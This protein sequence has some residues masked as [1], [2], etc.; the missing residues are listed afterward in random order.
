MKRLKLVTLWPI[1][2]LLLTV[3]A[4]PAMATTHTMTGNMYTDWGVNLSKAYSDDSNNLPASYDGWKPK[5]S[6]VDWIVENNI[7]RQYHAGQYSYGGTDLFN[8]AGSK[9]GTHKMKNGTSSSISDYDEPTIY[10]SDQGKYYIQPAGGEAYD[11]EALYFDDDS[12]NVYLAIV[13]SVP[14]GGSSGWKMGDIALDINDTNGNVAGGTT[15]SYEYGIKVLGGSFPAGSIIYKPTWDKPPSN[16]FPNDYPFTIQSGTSAGT[17][18]KINYTS[19]NVPPDNGFSNSVIEIS[20]PRNKLGNP[21]KDQLSNI[22]LTI[23]CGN[24][25]IELKPVRFK[26]DIPE[27]PSIVLPV[28]SILGLVFIYGSRKIN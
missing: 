8:W 16:E 5:D 11:I 20:I 27:F 6:S 1:S 7:D 24:D 17:V 22:H 10:C 19:D 4:V 21:S 15:T 14:L 25:L 12:K 2:L 9:Y 23:G 3:L 26:T 28:A 18:N 13:T